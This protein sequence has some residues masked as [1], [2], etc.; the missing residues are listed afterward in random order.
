MYVVETHGNSIFADARL[1][2]DP[3]A[4]VI[5]AQPQYP[6]QDRQDLL[7][8]SPTGATATVDIGNNPFAWRLPGVILGALTAGLLY[9]LARILFQRR[10]VAIFVGILALADGMAFVQSRI[11]MNDVYVGFFIVAA[12]TLFAALW[13]GAIR[14]R[15]AFWVLMPVVGLLLG[16]A[17]A[18]KWVGLYALAGIGILILARSALGRLLIIVGMIGAT[19][20]LGYMALSVPSG[21]T[22]GGNLTFML[23]MIALTIAAVAISVL[24]PIA[25]SVEEVRFA[26]AAPA[27]AGILAILVALP[28][29]K[30]NSGVVLGPVKATPW[31]TPPWT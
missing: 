24:H 14:W 25:W 7:L 1:P 31:A 11:G 12:Y 3:K 5:D 28:L 22:S 13:I 8:F 18:S 4:W 21:A 2:F 30:M 9:V 15:W 6:S 20:V 29:G 26:V 19:T 10:S 23:I 16:L 27:A 17:I